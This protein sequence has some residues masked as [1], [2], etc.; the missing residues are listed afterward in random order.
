MLKLEGGFSCELSMDWA[1]ELPD[2]K[3][4]GM[5]PGGG[6]RNVW[7]VIDDDEDDDDK[8]GCVED[9]EDELED[10]EAAEPGCVELVNGGSWPK[11]EEH[12]AA[13]FDRNKLLRLFR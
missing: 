3:G 6:G 13:R 10:D 5:G 8:E 12:A 9:A 7:A 1:N 4:E 11:P 2:K